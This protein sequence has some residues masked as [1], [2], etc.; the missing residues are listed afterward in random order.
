MKKI[1]RTLALVVCIAAVSSIP[2]AALTEGAS[3]YIYDEWGQSVPA[4]VAYQLA[5]VVSGQSCGTTAFEQPQDLFCDGTNIFIS[6]TQNDRIVVLDTDYRFVREITAVNAPSDGVSALKEPS[7]VFV[8]PDGFLYICDTGNE[9]VIK[10]DA[11]LNCRLILTKPQTELLSEE[12]QFRPLKVVTNRANN[13]LVVADGIYMGFVNYDQEGVFQG[14][15]GGNRVEVTAEVVV[16]HLW[17]KLFSEE[18][19]EASARTLP[20]E[21]SNAYVHNNLI[22]A[23]V[24]VSTTSQDELKKL[25]AMGANILRFRNTGR[26]YMQNDFGDLEKTYK[27]GVVDDNWFVAVDVNEQGNIALLDANRGHIFIYDKDCNLLFIIGGNGTDNLLQPADIVHNGDQYLVLDSGT[28]NIKVYS[29]TVYAQK[30]NTALGHYQNNE[31]QK[32]N[33]LWTE[34]LKHYSNSRIAYNGLGKASMQQGDFR[35]ACTYFRLAGER[36]EYSMAFREYRNQIL[37][38]H[39]LWMLAVLVAVIVLLRFLIRRFILWMGY[40]LKKRKV[41]FR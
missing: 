26:R 24:R 17:K 13:I 8:D 4:P 23:V 21:Y 37:E 10:V 12:V 32:A 7:G 25:N 40:D 14:F 29:P 33:E 35:Q 6:D 18:Q 28:G 41:R 36:Q 11:D 5:E 1:L 16:R 38:K 15:F 39:V 3:S 2:V 20:I 27:N 30:V 9:R 19:N 34:I 31:H 22:Y